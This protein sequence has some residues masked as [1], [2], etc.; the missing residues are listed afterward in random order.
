MDEPLVLLSGMNCSTRMW[1]GVEPALA[2]DRPAVSV[3]HRPLS[4]DSV[5]GC[6]DAVLTSLPARFAVA[7]FSLGAV[8]AMAVMRRSPHRVTRLCL[9]SANPY[10][11]TAEQ[12]LRWNAMR[13]ELATGQTARDIQRDLLPVLLSASAR[14]PVLDEQVLAMAD[15]IGSDVLDRQLCM[16]LSRAD[17]RLTLAE[18]DVPTLILAAAADALCPVWKHEEMHDSIPTSRLEVLDGVGHL[19]TME[20]PTLVTRQILSWLS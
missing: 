10:A 12:G 8:V 13:R 4:S 2:R 9:M 3:L 15:E 7:G 5:D 16:Q 20:A 18:V 11:P 1:S 6:A 17:E 14:T 19:S